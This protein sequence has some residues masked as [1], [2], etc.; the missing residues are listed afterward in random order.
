MRRSSGF[1]ARIPL[2]LF[3]CLLLGGCVG[4]GQWGT[5]V[6]LSS[7]NLASAARNAALDPHTWVPLATAGLL[8]AADV[9]KDWSE[10]LAEN[11]DIFG[12]DA[13]DVSDDL[14]DLATA[15]YVITALVAPSDTAADKAKG[16]MVGGATMALDGALNKGLKEI[17]GRERPDETNDYSMPSGHASKAASRTAMAIRNLDYIDMPGWSRDVASWSLR[18][19]AV[20]TGLARVEAERHYLSDVIVGYAIGQFVARFMHEAF[21]VPDS[22]GPQI[23]FTPVP[24]GGALTIKV[25]LP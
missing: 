19:V 18:G 7:G 24:E 15:A 12:D 11:Q 3:G 1:G 13:E 23:S 14:R 6:R 4:Q 20:G 25:P 10:D 5:E 17:T 8:I 22:G 2:I 16:L 21:F 9:D